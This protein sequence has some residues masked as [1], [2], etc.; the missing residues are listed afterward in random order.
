MSSN[1]DMEDGKDV[2]LADFA[3]NELDKQ[4]G[5][6]DDVKVEGATDAKADLSPFDPS[7]SPDSGEGARLK[8]SLAHLQY[9][10]QETAQARQLS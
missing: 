6:A 3:I 5:R 10:A 8:V 9:E 7:I 2:G 1:L 4:D